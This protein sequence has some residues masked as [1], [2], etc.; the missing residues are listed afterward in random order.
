[1]QAVLECCVVVDCACAVEEGGEGVGYVGVGRRGGVL[2]G[3]EMG[4]GG[5][6]HDLWWWWWW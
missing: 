3:E 1:M 5:E 2:A 6:I 4:E